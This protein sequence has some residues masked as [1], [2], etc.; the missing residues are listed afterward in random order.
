VDDLVLAFVEQRFFHGFF[1]FLDKKQPRFD[2][3]FDKPDC[4]PVAWCILLK[5]PGGIRCGVPVRAEDSNRRAIGFKKRDVNSLFYK[6]RDRGRMDGMAPDEKEVINHIDWEFSCF[7]ILQH[8][9]PI[10]T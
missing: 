10:P 4:I 6:A 8:D 3:T 1:E 9:Q 7:I 5:C 2:C